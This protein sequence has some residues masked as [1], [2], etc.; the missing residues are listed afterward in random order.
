MRLISS[1]CLLIFFVFGSAELFAQ[2]TKGFNYQ[3]VARDNS[4]AT[5]D[6]TNVNLR[7]QIRDGS[8]TGTLIY[9]ETHAMSTNAFGLLNTQ[10]GKGS[11][12]IGDFANIDWAADLYLLVELNGSG[13][14]TALLEAVPYAKMATDM[15]L[16]DLKD[17]NVS[18]P[19]T[20]QVLTWDGSGWVAA[21]NL[22]LSGSGA[23]TV[24]G[25]YPNYTINSTDNVD[26]ADADPTNEMQSLSLSGNNLS[27]SNGNSIA[28]PTGTT[29]T[30]GSGINLSGGTIS[31]TAPDQTVNI[32]GNGATSV[33]GSYPN[34][35]ISSTDNVNDADADPNNEIQ[36]LSLSGN[37]LSISNGNSIALPTGTTYTAG[38]DINI[39]GGTI[40]NTAPDQTVN[41]S[42]G[43]ATTVTGTYPNF[44]INSTDN[45]ND[46]DASTTN[47]IQNLSLSGNT[48]SLSAG[49]GSVN[50]ASFTS[51][52]T[53]SGSN[54]Y[55]STGKIGIGD[56]SPVATL[57]VGN[58]DKFQVH[59]AE[60]D[61]IFTD[62]QASIR[63]A[64]SS[65]SN[66]PMMQMF[67][68]GINN[69]TRMLIAHSP[70][71][72]NWGIQYNDTSDAFSWIGDNIPV[73]HIQLAGAQRVGVGTA[74]P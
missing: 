25:T 19:S 33:S 30:A 10:I 54:L 24:S 16:D 8:P 46:A 72:P 20:N 45:V 58:G 67:S 3:A 56:N 29:Y 18:A 15:Q 63:F 71:F 42:G 40:S 5:L 52:W 26:D 38:S 23:T 53:N 47:E 7:F 21:D 73:F 9:Q 31:N 12:E 14:D 36:N 35:S 51:P 64:N 68:N 60:G 70:N 4:G 50:L 57:T 55:F 17:A 39:S 2:S 32:S 66:Q 69:S 43:G 48:L 59:G 11:T 65:G 37:N 41:I 13:V 22:N 28:L 27:I 61:V 6:N 34:F 49:G 1:L 74:N 44:V 62:D